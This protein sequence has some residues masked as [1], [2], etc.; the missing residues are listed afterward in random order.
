MGDVKPGRV[1]PGSTRTN[2]FALDCG[3][4]VEPKPL[5]PTERMVLGA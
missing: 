4:G 2:D 1:M 5:A 3:G